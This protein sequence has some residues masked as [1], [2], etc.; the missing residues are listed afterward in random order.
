MTDLN[1]LYICD[2][3]GAD[4]KTVYKNNITGEILKDCKH[5]GINN[6]EINDLRLSEVIKSLQTTG[7]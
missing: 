1:K 2:N 5:C 3:C 6:D 7:E 4:T